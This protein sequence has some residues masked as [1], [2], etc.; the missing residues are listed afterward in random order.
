MIG[1]DNKEA[2]QFIDKAANSKSSNH[3]LIMSMV[4]RYGIGSYPVDMALA[5]TMLSLACEDLTNNFGQFEKAKLLIE[6]DVADETSTGLKI[7]LSLSKIEFPP[8]LLEMAFCMFEFLDESGP[9]YN[10]TELNLIGNIFC[11]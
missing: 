8:A 2:E 9:G 6:S 5:D 10:S 11:Q 3:Q 1:I 7:I 4:H